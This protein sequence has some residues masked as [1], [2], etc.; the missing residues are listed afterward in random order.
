MMLIRELTPEILQWERTVPFEQC[1]EGVI[2][3]T[4]DERMD[5][6]SSFKDQKR[7]RS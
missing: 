4:T 2:G 5:N 3:R 7:F 1:K 6:E